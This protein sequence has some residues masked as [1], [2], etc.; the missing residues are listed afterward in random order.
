MKSINESLVTKSL[1]VL[2]TAGALLVAP[3]K[4]AQARLAGASPACADAMC[5]PSIGPVCSVNRH[6][7]AD[8]FYWDGDCS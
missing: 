3:G 8:F 2:S 5:C 7:Y 1:F 4:H 6:E